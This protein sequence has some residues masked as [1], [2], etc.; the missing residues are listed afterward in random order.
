M[1]TVT[2]IP[3]RD[4]VYLVSNRDEKHFRADALPPIEYS[5]ESGKMVFPRDPDA[6][7]T[8]IAMHENGNAIVFLNG[9]VEAHD[10]VPPYRKSR[11]LILLDLLNASSA[12]IEFDS[13]D[14]LGIEPFTAV[15]WDNGKL[16]E[17]IWT[18][19]EKHLTEKDVAVPHI[20]SSVTLY[21]ETT[22]SRR[23]QWFD[24]WL[25]KNK[26]PDLEDILHFHQFTGEGDS[27]NDLMMNRDG[28]VFTVSI[29]GMR[30]KETEGEMLY[31]DIKNNRRS[32]A[33]LNFGQTTP[34]M[35]K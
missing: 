29:T 21:E 8:W 32:S 14:L 19:S 24:Q 15:A 9:G 20:W 12:A 22:R 28:Y 7:G 6:G 31:I 27:H 11:G 35:L 4:N 5:F 17:C 18:G 10:P 3:G 30:L 1:C 2:F 16:Y 34:A 33:V 23:R 26:E 13:M 25:E